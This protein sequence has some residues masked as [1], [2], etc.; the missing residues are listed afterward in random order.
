MAC[1]LTAAD[2]SWRA[3]S[4]AVIE[5]ALRGATVT[6]SAVSVSEDG[7]VVKIVDLVVRLP[8]GRLVAMSPPATVLEVHD[9]E[10]GWHNMTV[11]QDFPE[12]PE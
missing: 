10:R 1:E 3:R 12:V 11:Q 9:R 4:E 7:R 8:D 2:V 5:D 6:D